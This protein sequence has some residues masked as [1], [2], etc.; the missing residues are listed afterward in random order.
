M[1]ETDQ[2]PHVFALAPG[3]DFPRA[4]VDGLRAR[5]GEA[6][7]EALARVQILVNTRRMARRLREIFDAG[8]PC[9]LPRIGLV[10]DLGEGWD[11]AH[12]PPPAPRLRRRLELVQLVTA[13]I[14]RQPDLAPRSA[15]FDLADSLAALM[16]EMHGEGVSPEAIEALDITDQSGHW[17]R[18]K[19]FLGIVRPYFDAAATAPDP[20]T[21]QRRV[22]EHLV[23]RWQQNPPPHPLIVAGSTG[24]RGAT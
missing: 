13:L 5:L 12:L 23:A 22:I 1:F 2:T 18:I 4:L 8:P 7:P 20:E 14:D 15:A 19:A 17:A 21:R 9:L 16:D 11:L 10:T 3:V 6:P 24:S